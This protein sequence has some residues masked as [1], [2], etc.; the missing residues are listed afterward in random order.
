MARKVLEPS[1]YFLSV[2]L[3]CTFRVLKI[4]IK[5]IHLNKNLF[6]TLVKICCALYYFN[7]NLAFLLKNVYP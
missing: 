3:C 4:F 2:L 6:I 7:D 1:V 5:T